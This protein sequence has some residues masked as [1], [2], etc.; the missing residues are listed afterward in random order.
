MFVFPG[1]V[2]DETCKKCIIFNFFYLSHIDEK[3]NMVHTKERPDTCLLILLSLNQMI[4][5][6]AKL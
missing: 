5:I 3:H 4:V 2:H 6:R 1:F